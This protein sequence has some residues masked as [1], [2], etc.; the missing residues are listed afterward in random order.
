M[1]KRKGTLDKPDAEFLAQANTINSQCNQ[2]KTDWKI[3]DDRLTTFDGL[4]GVANTAYAANRDKATKNATTSARK[5]AAFG[6]LKH[7]LG[8]FID[9]LEVNFSVPDAALDA[10]GLRSRHHHAH[11]PLPRPTDEV[12]LSV[13]KQHDEMTLYASRVE[14]GHPTAATA[15]ATHHGFMLRYKI[16]GE[17]HY[18][19]VISTR[20]HHTLFFEREDEGKRVYLSAAWVSP[21]LETGPW[22][23]EFSEV[24]G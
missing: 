22:S 7:F 20:L 2:H 3:D 23:D 16:E 9:Y 5:K 24:I 1:S 4:L 12:V 17:E 11:L 13:R 14:L 18:R 6:E 19:T 15:L 8:P 21:R 10:M